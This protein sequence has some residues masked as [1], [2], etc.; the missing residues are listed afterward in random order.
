M[1][2]N[3]ILLLQETWLFENNINLLGEID[4]NFNYIGKGADN[5]DP[6]LPYQLPRGYGG[7]AVIW[8]K[9]IDHLLNTIK[10]GNERIQCIEF[11]SLSHNILIV[12]VYMPSRGSKK[13]DLE[14][15]ETIEYLYD[16]CE[17]YKSTHEILIG[18]DMNVDL[19]KNECKSDKRTL[20]IKSFIEQY[21]LCFDV[22]GKTYVLS[23]GV[24]CSE[25]DYFLK[26]TANNNYSIKIVLSDIPENLSDHYPISMSLKCSFKKQCTK[27]VTTLYKRRINWEKIDKETYQ[28]LINEKIQH[29]RVTETAD[30]SS[31]TENTKQ[32]IQIINDSM[33]TF[34]RKPRS[35]KAKPKLRVWNHDIANSLN[36]L[37]WSY[38]E[39]KDAGKPT[40]NGNLSH[41]T[42]KVK[43]K[44]F[45]SKCRIEHARRK[46][47]EREKIMDTKIND[48]KLFYK[49]VNSQK[50][51]HNVLEKLNVNGKELESQE[52]II[53]G[54]H[55]HFSALA[56]LTNSDEYD[57][58]YHQQ[59]IN[60]VSLM[61]DIVLDT[62]VEPVTEPEL[63]EAI[64][65]INT[66][67][68]DDIFGMTIENIKYGVL[69][70]IIRECKD[71][72]E[73][74]DIILLDAKSAF[75]VVD[76]KHLLRRIY[77]MGIQDTHWTL[78]KNIHENTA[79]I[80]QWQGNRSEQ[81]PVLQG[82]R[83]G[84]VLSADLYKIYV[85]PLLNRL[86]DKEIGC[87]IGTTR[88]NATACADD[89]TLNSTV[90]KET[91]I[92]IDIAE[93]FAK[94]ERYHLQP[95]KTEH[96]HI[97]PTTKSASN[98][99]NGTYTI[100]E[101]VIKTVDSTTHLGIKRTSTKAQSTECN[102]DNNIIK[103]R[104]TLYKL[105]SDEL[106][107]YQRTDPQTRLHLFNLY[108]LPI[109]TYGLEVILPGK[110]AME[111]LEV[112]QKKSIKQLLSLPNNTADAAIYIISGVL[113]VEAQIHKKALTLLNNI[114]LQDDNSIEKTLA[115]RQTIVKDGK[116]N[117]W[118]IEIRRLLWFYD[119]DDIISVISN[120]FKRIVWKNKV[121][122]V[123]NYKWKEQILT[124]AVHYK[125]LQHMNF[126]FYQ[127]GHTH[128]ILRI[129]TKSTRDITRIPVKLKLLVGT[130]IL[131]S[132]KANFNQN[133]VN[134][135]C[136]LCNESSETLEHFILECINLQT[137][138]KP[139]I[140]DIIIEFNKCAKNDGQWQTLNQIERVRYLIDCSHLLTRPT[141]DDIQRLA[142]LEYQI[143]RLLYCLHTER[144]RQYAALGDVNGSANRLYTIT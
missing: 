125:S 25:I 99:E 133:S 36:A 40:E 32:I 14:Y 47:Y 44:E 10:D 3:Q 131:Q 138:R 49:L 113:P 19:S 115:Q 81:F 51:K 139:I 26:P 60:E 102:T 70:E 86:Q 50:R 8:D 31:I 92:L 33:Q 34:S 53:S 97:T 85:N 121:K 124:T 118:F 130:Y 120:P 95:K 41:T 63:D 72:K 96:L 122:N 73:N 35:M 66:G 12:S 30:I 22:S 112:F 67:K 21:S 17:K 104:K 61:D 56:D 77:H 78:L 1:K 106:H 126:Q 105:F 23:T 83:Q 64:N 137:V 79:S 9:S 108:V 7:V 5:D 62:E 132:T 59:V 103:A 76:H 75:D 107:G 111:K 144:Y 129:K 88:C 45:R 24:E 93:N 28:N 141:E 100:N 54:F 13:S 94:Q 46:D 119:L 142:D 48:K 116:S 15:A 109:L 90:K 58:D 20:L 6:I 71:N 52:N 37:R 140:N 29:L 117:S 127:P 18:G 110:C 42:M 82:V 89:I 57:S 136:Q 101:N 84:G 80:V 74:V 68:A 91:Q 11:K 134:P 43:K 135:T 55:E 16:I 143:R 87:K 123:V 4:K 2:S 128:P 114:C 27:Q 98:V 65:S 39:W 38:K 69:E